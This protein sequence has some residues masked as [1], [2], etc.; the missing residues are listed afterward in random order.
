MDAA[1]LNAIDNGGLRARQ[2]LLPSNASPRL[3][4]IQLPLIQLTDPGVIDSIIGRRGRRSL[5]VLHATDRSA[6]KLLMTPMRDATVA[7]PVLRRA[8]HRNRTLWPYGSRNTVTVTVPSARE[9][10]DFT[11]VNYTVLYGYP[12]YG[13]LRVR[14]RRI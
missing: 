13:Y 14:M 12:V 4:T 9:R 1:L 5:Q 3:D 7:G 10:L 2:A 8:V 6:A 11:A